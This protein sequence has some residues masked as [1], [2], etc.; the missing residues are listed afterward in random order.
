MIIG[1]VVPDSGEIA[2]KRILI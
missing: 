2:C 1:D